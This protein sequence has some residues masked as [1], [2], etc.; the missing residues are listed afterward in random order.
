M[1]EAKASNKDIFNYNVCSQ[2]LHEH[3]R[4]QSRDFRHAVPCG[5]VF[6]KDCVGRVEAEQKSGKSICRKPTCNRE[7]ASASEFA[8]SWV[9]ERAERIRIEHAALFGDQGDVGSSTTAVAATGGD[10]APSLCA[11]HCL[12]FRAVLASSHIPICSECMTAVDADVA[13]QTF[14]EAMAALDS[15]NAST[16]AEVAKQ[17]AALAEPT[18]TPDEFC[19]NVASWGAQETARIRAWE[20]REVKHVQAVAEEIV[21][22]VQEVCARRIEIGASMITQRTGL[23]ASLEELNRALIDLPTEPATRLT[24]MQVVYAERK[25]LSELLAGSQIDV[26]SA[27]RLRWWA[28]LPNLSPLFDRTVAGSL[29]SSILD[30]AKSSLDWALMHFGSCRQ[31]PVLPRLVRSP[32]QRFQR[33]AHVSLSVLMAVTSCQ[34]VLSKLPAVASRT[35]LTSLA[36]SGQGP[37]QDPNGRQTKRIRRYR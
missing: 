17:V 14:D 12:P 31:F 3:S 19:D 15:T 29:A 30:A 16:S 9:S 6:C 2:C 10:P 27:A 5:H 25:R 18:F 13:L 22:L 35:L 7:L 24:R 4:S 32:P 34:V 36:G 37:A 1:S 33:S 23:R 28:Q 21:Q 8:V 20:E 26:P 11:K